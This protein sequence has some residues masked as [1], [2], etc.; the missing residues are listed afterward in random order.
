MIIRKAI[1]T[2]AASIAKVHV[3]G[4]RTTYKGIV[5]NTYLNRLSYEEHEKNWL[6]GIQTNGIYVAENE[7]GEVVGFATG[8]KERT[9]K[10][11][12]YD[13]ELYAIYLL[14]TAQG[15]GLGRKLFE[16]IVKDLQEKKFTSMLIWAL[17]D[18]PACHFYERLGGKKVDTAE[19]E[20]DGKQLQEVAFGWEKLILGGRE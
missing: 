19:I 8:G 10:Y 11:K 18:N 2:D 20:I 4:W 9:G 5:P 17:A 13:G 16:A 3:D 6:K 1:E 15:E 14:E 7:R 12:A